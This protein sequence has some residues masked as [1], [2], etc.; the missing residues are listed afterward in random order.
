MLYPLSLNC[1]FRTYNDHIFS[2]NWVVRRNFVNLRIRDDRSVMVA[3]SFD[4]IVC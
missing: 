1:I 2:V 4:N 3:R